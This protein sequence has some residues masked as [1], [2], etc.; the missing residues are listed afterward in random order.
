MAS[1][2]FT[3]L[4]ISKSGTVARLK[5]KVRLK[6]GEVFTRLVEVL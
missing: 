6:Y 5:D 4:H 1:L 2:D 3:S